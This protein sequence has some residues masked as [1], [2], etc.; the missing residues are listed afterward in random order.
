MHPGFVGGAAALPPITM[1]ARADDILPSRHASAR[2][3]NHVIEVKFGSWQPL[4][5]VLAGIA[6]ARE[7]VEARKTHVAF[8]YALIG[9]QQEDSRDTDKSVDDPEL[10]VLNFDRKIAPTIEIE[11]VILLVNGFSYTLIKQRKRAF[12]RR[13]VNRQI[14]A[15]ENQDLAVEQAHSRET[16]RNHL[17]R[18]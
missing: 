2:A 9:G 13:N 7:D 14:R 12:D 5:A 16:G 3:R 8:G 17:G 6:V 18:G 15:I 1:M 11:G 4:V 10:F